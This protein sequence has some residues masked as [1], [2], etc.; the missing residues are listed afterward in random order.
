MKIQELVRGKMIVRTITP[1]ALV[2]NS[3]N[4]A[5]VRLN[6]A[7]FVIL[8]LFAMS[9]CRQ[10]GAVQLITAAIATRLSRL[11]VLI[12]VI[13]Y[14]ILTQ[15]RGVQQNENSGPRFGRE[16]GRWVQHIKIKPAATGIKQK[17]K[18]EKIYK[19]TSEK[20]KWNKRKINYN[21][22]EHKGFLFESYL[23]GNND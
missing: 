19:K 16:N 21:A 20:E 1:D 9:G 4:W 7:N 22:Y 5:H 8:R 14:T 13:F 11:K 18:E 2:N 23:I 15:V 12:I 10:G 6:L 3:V 17:S